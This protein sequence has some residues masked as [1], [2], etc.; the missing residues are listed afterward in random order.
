M[1]QQPIRSLSR[2]GHDGLSEVEARLRQQVN[3]LFARSLHIRHVD[4]G[5][6]NACESE[7]KLLTSPYY[8]MHRLGLFFTPSPRHA[9]LL[10]VTGAITRAMIPPLRRTYEAMP[11]TRLV[12]AVGAC[13]CGGGV[14][15][16][17][18]YTAGDLSDILPVDAYIPGCPPTPLALLAGLLLAID[19]V[20][21]RHERNW[22]AIPHDTLA[23]Q[24]CDD[25]VDAHASSSGLA[26][27]A[28]VGGDA[29]EDI[30]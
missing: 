16:P 30:R 7:V 25:D 20:G 9:D 19:R 1:R 17:S 12:V 29:R 6:C 26:G 3:R 5:S 23:T 15:G 2:R 18:A 10:L 8:D 21:E 24:P 14:F 4:A 13:A 22:S 28:G 11:D 27:E